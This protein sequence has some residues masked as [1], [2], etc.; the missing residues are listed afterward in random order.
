MKIFSLFLSI[1][2]VFPLCAAPQDEEALLASL[3]AKTKKSV[4]E[5]QQLL[6]MVTDYKK[7]RQAFVADAANNK[8]ATALV[9]KAAQIF[10]LIEKNRLADLF[11]QPFMEE[12]SYFTEVGKR[13]R[14]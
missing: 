10:A 1:I 8:L 3:I 13:N 9:R 4:I 2:V 11:P 7:T 14:D 12:I 5:Q 6:E